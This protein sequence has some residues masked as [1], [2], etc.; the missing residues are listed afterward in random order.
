MNKGLTGRQSWFIHSHFIHCSTSDSDRMGSARSVH[1]LRGLFKVLTGN[2]LCVTGEPLALQPRRVAREAPAP[3]P[4]SALPTSNLRSLGECL[5][6][7]A[8]VNSGGLLCRQNSSVTASSRRQN[9]PSHAHD[10]RSNLVVYKVEIVTG[11]FRMAGTDDDVSIRLIGDRGSSPERILKN[12]TSSNSPSEFTR[13]SRRVFMIQCPDVGNLQGLQVGLRRQPGDTSRFNNWYLDRV[14]VISPSGHKTVF[15]YQGWL[16]QTE[17]NKLCSMQCELKPMSKAT[18]CMEVLEFPLE[19]WCSAYNIPNPDSMTVEKRSTKGM[20]RKNFGHGGEDAY[21]VEGPNQ[22]GL[23]AL[24][25]SDGVY[26]WRLQGIDAGLFSQQLMLSCAELFSRGEADAGSILQMSDRKLKES[27]IKGSATACIVLINTLTGEL[28]SANLGDSG[29]CVLRREDEAWHMLYKSPQ[30]EH[31]FGCPY[32]LGHHETANHPDDAML[33]TR[34]VAPNDMIILGSDGLFDNMHDHEIVDVVKKA[35]LELSPGQK[36][37]S[38]GASTIAKSIANRAFFNSMDKSLDTPY[39]RA[40]TEEFEMVYSGGKA[41][42]ITV[43]VAV[44]G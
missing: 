1:R 30:Q 13:G 31:H 4:R 16:G 36:K 9:E 23:K 25:V 37:S 11:D 5:F 7:G 26:M 17:D 19:V 2:Q 14:R 44:V 10:I 29:F 6:V 40:A 39:S 3:V 41:D 12:D 32:Q 35:W 8:V 27:A 42:D 20:M 18:G 28:N 22:H 15:S 33:L 24:G 34:R 38:V 43:V 21:F